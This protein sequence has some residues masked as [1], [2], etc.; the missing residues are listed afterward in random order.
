VIRSD[1]TQV[2]RARSYFLI[3]LFAL[4]GFTLSV[5]QFFGESPDFFDYQNFFDLTRAEDLDVLTLA[6][7]EPF[8]SILTVMFSRVVFSNVMTYSLIV[9]VTMIAKGGI[10]ERLT[11]AKSA[12]FVLAFFYFTRYFSL[13]ELTQL[14]V[15][16]ASSIVLLAAMVYWQ[17]QK[18]TGILLILL[19]TCFHFSSA[20][21]LPT[22]IMSRYVKR[23]QA[24]WVGVGTLLFIANFSALITNVLAD[25]IEIL[26][27]YSQRGFG[28]DKPNPFSV[29]LLLDWFFIIYSF[30]IW[31]K[32][33]TIMRSVVVVEVMGMGIFYG[34]TDFPV[35]AHRFRE[36]YS[37]LW[38]IYVA[39]GLKHRQTKMI[40]YL[41]VLSS[42][43]LY[44]YL[45]IF[46]GTFFR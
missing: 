28:D 30:V 12:F 8:F 10:F 22:L 27:V 33:P 3:A 1:F 42:A 17:G 43:A 20:A 4:T 41:L 45:F 9:L 7:F 5:T 37:V 25:Y 29:T 13:H 6:R 40:S 46:S 26:F 21:F 23:K 11:P 34:G 35:I 15:S 39:E 14:R 19:A 18:R 44:S 31:N 24:I 2:Y 32:L 16:C 38:L 36:F